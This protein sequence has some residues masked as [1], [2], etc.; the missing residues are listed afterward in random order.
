MWPFQIELFD[1]QETGNQ[2]DT[3]SMLNTLTGAAQIGRYGRKCAILTQKFGYLGPK[4][5]TLCGNRDFCQQGISPVCPRLKLS[6]SDHPTKNSVSELGVIFWGSPL[7]LA[8]SGLCH[9]LRRS[10][11]NFGPFSTKLGVTVQAIKKGTHNDNG[12]GPG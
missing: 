7:F 11:L 6:K 10:T 1:K 4:V 3:F 8:V 9:C 2:W 5:N 12:P